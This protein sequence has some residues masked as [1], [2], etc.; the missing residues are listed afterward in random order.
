MALS[1][2]RTALSDLTRTALLLTVALILSW[3]ESVLPFHIPVPGV[4]LGFANIVTVFVLYEYSFP[5]ALLFG[6]L[7]ALLSALFL[8][9]L[10]GLAFSLCGAILSVAGMA[11]LKRIPL[12]SSFGV[13]V[14][15]AVLHGAGQLLAASVLLSPAVWVWLPAVG[16]SSALCGAIT[17]IPFRI[18]RQSAPRWMPK[19]RQ[20][21][22]KE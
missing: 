17:W 5:A 21:M 13:S 12:F 6:V 3:V 4:K 15:G 2:K 10:S 9:R 1:G 16:I 19:K 20:N 7:R 18:L 11:L 22:K 14:C 8:G